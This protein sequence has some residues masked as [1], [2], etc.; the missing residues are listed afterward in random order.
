MRRRITVAIVGTVI[1]ALVVAGL[2]T[3]LLASVTSRRAI[4]SDLRDQATALASVFDEATLLRVA[5]GETPRGRLARL[6]E[7]LSLNGIGYLV[8]PRGGSAPVGE[9]PPGIE[10]EDLDADALAAGEPVS[11]RKGDLVFAA[12][13]A[14]TRNGVTQVI[15][16]TNEQESVVAPAWGWFLLAGSAAVLLA[17]LVALRLSRSLTRPVRHASSTA[18]RI[19]DGDLAAR[20]PREGTSGGGAEIEELVS[21]INVMATNL[22]RSRALERQF[23]LSV[24]HDLRTPLTSIRG[25]AEA[26]QDGAAG[27]PTLVGDVIEQEA[28]RLERLVGDLLLLA[29]LEGTGFTFDR[30][31]HDAREIVEDTVAGFEHRAEI[32]GVDLTVRA[33]D[34]PQTVLVDPDRYAQ[35]VANLVANACR[36]AD[37]VVAVTLWQEEGRV[38]LAVDDDGPGIAD[39]D[40]PHVF[41]RLYTATKNPKVRESGSGL[42][43]AIVRELVE[44][45]DGSVVARRSLLGGAEFVVSFRPVDV[46]TTATT[47]RAS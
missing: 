32:D 40:L 4:E 5:E 30:A 25:Y 16:L 17:F 42:G 38:H 27:D 15:V 45:M 10:P 36:F 20:V 29:R 8:V 1:A 24:S 37:Q 11:G 44:G 39:D 43:L 33:P 9:L 26:L 3:I 6:S 21:S 2:G 28:K 7:T 34:S 12:A 18:H 14:V 31:P 46:S 19:A 13:A 47:V 23:L 35:V 41:E 22:E